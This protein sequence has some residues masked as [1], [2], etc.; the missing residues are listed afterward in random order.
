MAEKEEKFDRRGKSKNPRKLR[1]LPQY[2]DLSEEEFQKVISDMEAQD[3]G[4]GVSKVFED[5][6][7]E[8]LRKFEEDYDLSDMKI[9]D[10]AVLRGLVQSIIALEDYEQQSFQLRAGGINPD[11]AFA[12]QKL[13]DIMSTLRTDIS[14]MQNDLSITRKHR[15]S[16]Q[17]Q[18]VLAYIE[19]LKDKAR[20]FLESRQAYIL[21]DKCNTLLATVWTLYPNSNNKISLTCQQKD[22]DG[23]LCGNKIT[24]TTKELLEK[25]Q[26]NRPEILPDSMK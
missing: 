21:C 25:K 6:I 12:S 13:Q 8:E 16:D 11:N 26:T 18:S 23:V 22:K 15:K 19:S 20:K 14:R 10:R 1:N 7:A 17:E 5:R 9:N 4:L 3:L 24:V 2:R